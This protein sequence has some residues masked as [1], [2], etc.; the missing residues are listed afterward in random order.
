MQRTR[1]KTRPGQTDIAN[2]L[3]V[4]VSTVSR[5]LADSPAI[6]DDIKRQVY[7]VALKIGYPVKAHTVVERLDQIVVLT[8]VA[9]FN[10][11]RSSIYYG[12][13]EGIKTAA[14]RSGTVV[15][16][17]ITQSRTPLPADLRNKLGP[18]TGCVFLGIT[19]SPDV[20][21]YLHDQRIPALVCNGVDEELLIDSISPANYSGGRLM[22]R[23]LMDKGHR[24][25]L[26]FGGVHRTTLRRRASGFR[27]YV[28]KESG[29]DGAEIV[30]T[31]E[32]RGPLSDDLLTDFTDW[33]ERNRGDAT[34]LFCYNDGAA[35][36]AIEAA[37]ILGISV[38]DDL[39]IA[40]FDDMPIADLTTPGLTTYRIDW[41]QIGLQCVALLTARM[42]NPESP[43]QYLQVGGTFV[44]RASVITA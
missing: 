31:Y 19:P 2:A 22:A 40:G 25:F 36:W 33:L 41:Q 17:S 27:Q 13:L 4:S 18:K 8:S 23:Y 38:P 1:K 6:N 26:Y 42:E 35:A 28:E 34:A 5:A 15:S 20:A 11:T 21:Q 39:S 16:T 30:A 14:T 12:L 24:K 7:E 29:M 37:K 32:Q 44:E 3:G 10:D 9:G 43:T